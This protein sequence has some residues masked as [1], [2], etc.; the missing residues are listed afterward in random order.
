LKIIKIFLLFIKNKY[1]IE[2]LLEIKIKFLL[3]KIAIKSSFGYYRK[4]R[5][6]LWTMFWDM[7][8]TSFFNAY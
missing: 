5:L 6:F 2:I 8:C 1:R 4:N 7:W 3:L